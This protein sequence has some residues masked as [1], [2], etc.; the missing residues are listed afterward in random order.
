LRAGV[1]DERKTGLARIRLLWVSLA[2]E[3]WKVLS[4]GSGTANFCCLL[5][6]SVLEPQNQGCSLSPEVAKGN[7][8]S[9]SLPVG[10]VAMLEMGRD[11]S[12]GKEPMAQYQ[13]SSALSRSTLGTATLSL[14][15]IK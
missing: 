11:T 9:K 8:L 15:A 14:S 12:T 13:D 3:H 10:R 4:T 7:T 2:Q 1:P 6:K 5:L